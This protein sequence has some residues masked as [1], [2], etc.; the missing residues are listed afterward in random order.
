VVERYQEAKQSQH[1]PLLPWS[2]DFEGTQA[3]FSPGEGIKIY[4]FGSLDIL[5]L[6]VLTFFTCIETEKIL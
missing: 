3:N 5:S 6:R 1:L 4:M 2:R